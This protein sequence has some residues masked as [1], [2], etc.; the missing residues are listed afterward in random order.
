MDKPVKQQGPIRFEAVIPMLIVVGLIVLYFS[1]FFDTHLRRGIEYA[2]GQANGAE[3]NIGRLN[4]SVFDASLLIADVQMT[5]PAQPERNRLQVGEIRFRMLWDALL[6]GKVMIDEAAIEDVQIDTPRQRAGYVLPP[7]PEQEDGPSATNRMLAQ[8]KE[9]F[10]GNVVGDLAAIAAGTSASEQ[11]KVAGED[12]KSSAYLDGIQK[13]LDETE[14]QWRERMDVLPK[15]EDF[16][17]LRDR[18]AKVQLKDFKDA[19][20]VQ[21]SVKELQS[22]R[23]EFDAKSKPVGEAG[24]K[25]TG[26]MGVLRGSLGDLDQVVRDDVRGLQARMHLPSLDTAT[27][28][29]ALFG[30]DVLGQ[31][32]QARAYM[33]QARQY[34]PARSVEKKAKPAA[35][36]S[37]KGRDYA[38]GKPKGYP[39]FWLRRALLTSRLS[40][41]RGLSGEILD[42]ATDQQLVGRPLVATLKG[43]FPQQGVTGVKAELVI[44][45]RTA[46]PVE[47]LNL[48]VGRYAVAGRSLVNSENVTLGFAKAAASSGF[49]AELRGEKVD[50]RLSNRFDD[51][52]FETTAKSA[53]VREMMAASVAGL[54]TVGLD[55]RVSG[56]WSDLDWRLSTNLADALAKG[57]GRYL[58]A[59]MDEARK[60][61]ENLVNDKIGE[62]KQRLLARQG[63]LDARYKSQLAERKAQV[64]KMRAELDGA[65]SELD[66]RKN[67]AVDA[68]KQKLKQEAGKLLDKWRR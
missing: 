17:A 62:Q 5:N 63:E 41:E 67:A 64:D 32:Q 3:V 43:D 33:N 28:S 6:R 12:L 59:K 11:I 53:V 10:S 34:I 46:E 18:L 42:V 26:D 19:A 8:M 16:K 4:T 30:M 35:S 23:D 14:Q 55:A 44:D 27:L 58:Q 20:Q 37:R 25:L 22:I 51:A 39:A 2:A 68:E 40:G 66:K 65:R 54:N 48:E 7:E 38:F 57:M 21:A 31:L 36:K 50:M 13:S 56:S 15:G 9:E 60:R 1:L 49:V 47:R 29:R 45:H 52:A 24:T 61:I